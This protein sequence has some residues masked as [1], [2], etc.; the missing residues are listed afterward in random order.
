MNYLLEQ[1]PTEAAHDKHCAVCGSTDIEYVRNMGLY[2][3]NIMWEGKLCQR[4]RKTLWLCNTC[5]RA[6]T[7]NQFITE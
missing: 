6:F 7:S 3:T 2:P 4:V 5:G 1:D